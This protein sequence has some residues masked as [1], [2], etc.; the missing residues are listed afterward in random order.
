MAEASARH[1]FGGLVLVAGIL[2]VIL[3]F[4]GADALN[5]RQQTRDVAKAATGGNPDRA[6]ELFR[7]YGCTG[8]HTIPGIPGADG[9]VGAPL[10][11]LRKRVYIAGVIE[12]TPDNLI[13][14]IV[15]PQAFA[16]HVAMPATGITEAEARDLAAYLYA[17]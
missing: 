16:P 3:A 2:A 11:D 12:N 8:C 4:I 13:H 9:Q 1:D 6:P 10:A 7:K 5:D 17:Q 15:S 14:W